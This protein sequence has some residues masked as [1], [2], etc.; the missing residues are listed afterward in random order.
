MSHSPCQEE[1]QH[2]KSNSDQQPK[3]LYKKFFFGM[4]T[5]SDQEALTYVYI[6]QLMSPVR[7]EDGCRDGSFSAERLPWLVHRF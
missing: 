2:D 5:V 1:S 3:P 6:E 4:I 7:A